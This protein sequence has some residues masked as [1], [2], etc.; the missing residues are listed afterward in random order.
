MEKERMAVYADLPPVVMFAMAAREFAGK[1]QSIDNLTVTPD[2]LS[3]V[4]KQVQSAIKPVIGSSEM[5]Q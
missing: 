4:I 5:Q 1:L 2:M 3:N